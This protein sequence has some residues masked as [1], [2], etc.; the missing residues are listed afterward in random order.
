L[1]AEAQTATGGRAGAT[2]TPMA[3][4]RAAAPAVDAS[5]SEPAE[6]ATRIEALAD[7]GTPAEEIA[8]RLGVAPAEVRL[9]IGLKAARAARRRVATAEARAHA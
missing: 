2:V 5:A 9:I 6:I 7:A 1:V 4:A 3:A 8:R